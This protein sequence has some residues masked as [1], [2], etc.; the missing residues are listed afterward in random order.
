MKR[1]DFPQ[2][3]RKQKKKRNKTN[4]SVSGE[5]MPRRPAPPRPGMHRAND[6]D[7]QF[8]TPLLLLLLLLRTTDRSNCRELLCITLGRLDRDGFQ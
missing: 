8:R 7:H 5:E 3:E 1:K 6:S 4:G 2:K